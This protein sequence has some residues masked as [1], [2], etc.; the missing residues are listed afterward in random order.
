MNEIVINVPA[1][2]TIC[3]GIGTVAAAWKIISSP[4]KKL[5]DRFDRYDELLSNDKKRLDEL[6]GLTVDVRKDLN[7]VADITYQMLD[8]M[9]TNNNN[10]GMKETLDK[11]NEYYR[12]K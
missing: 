11:Y 5:N 10:G 4:V 6:Q 9:S 2:L 7:M 8:H 12:K 1:L 3:G